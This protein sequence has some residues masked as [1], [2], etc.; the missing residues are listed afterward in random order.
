MPRKSLCK[1]L[2]CGAAV[3]VTAVGGMSV[4]KALGGAGGGMD[5]LRR[6]GGGGRRDPFSWS[7]SVIRYK[8]E[9]GVPWPAGGGIFS[10]G[11]T[12]STSGRSRV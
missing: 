5:P 8:R 1:S 4:A 2:S 6:G 7:Y 10:K 12:M 3:I 9:D 11:L